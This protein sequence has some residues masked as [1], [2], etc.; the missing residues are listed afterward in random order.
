[1]FVL[2]MLTG[3]NNSVISMNRHAKMSTVTLFGDLSLRGQRSTSD[4]I[5]AAR[6]RPGSDLSSVPVD[7]G[8]NSTAILLVTF[9]SLDT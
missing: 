9:S 4:S 8:S 5:T 7:F 1:M 6:P 2:K 3:K